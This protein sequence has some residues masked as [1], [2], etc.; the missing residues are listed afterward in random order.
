MPNDALH[1]RRTAAEY[2][3]VSPSTIDRWRRAGLLESI[4]SGK[5]LRFRESWIDLALVRVAERAAVEAP[6]RADARAR[7]RPATAHPKS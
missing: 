1:T 3:K 6:A 2:A 7:L 4:G 5:T